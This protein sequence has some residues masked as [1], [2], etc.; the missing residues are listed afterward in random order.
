MNDKW[1]GSCLD[2]ALGPN[3]LSDKDIRRLKNFYMVQQAL[4]RE[5][6]EAKSLG[7]CK[8]TTSGENP[9]VTQKGISSRNDSKEMSS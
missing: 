9:L 6:L 4:A 7:I 5:L 8:T 3:N 2:L 1:L